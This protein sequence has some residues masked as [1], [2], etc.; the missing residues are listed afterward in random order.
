[1]LPKEAIAEFKELYLKHYKVELADEEASLRA[2]N[3]VALYEAVY[4]KSPKTTEL[5]KPSKK[6]EIT[7]EKI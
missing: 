2:N 5:Q 3:L 1:M 7:G 4:V 6:H